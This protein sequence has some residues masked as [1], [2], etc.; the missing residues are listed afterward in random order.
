MVYNLPADTT[1][2]DC[3]AVFQDALDQYIKEPVRKGWD[4]AK[5]N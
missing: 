5:D 4:M 1:T 3:T 2:E